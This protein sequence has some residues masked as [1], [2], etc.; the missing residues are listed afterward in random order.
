ME[1]ALCEQR[2][3]L[4]DVI[5]MIEEYVPIRMGTSA[6]R[7]LLSLIQLVK[8]NIQGGWNLSRSFA[9]NS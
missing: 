3:H 1:M 2:T 6:V 8:P 7:P 5:P 9:L 4:S